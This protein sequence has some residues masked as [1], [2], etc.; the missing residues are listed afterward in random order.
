MQLVVTHPFKSYVK[1]DHITDQELVEKFAQIYR[2]HV[3]KKIL[4]EPT[5]PVV[6]AK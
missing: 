4:E 6:D 5:V 1:G 3:V 2:D